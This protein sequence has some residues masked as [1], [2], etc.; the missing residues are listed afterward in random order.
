MVDDLSSSK[1][2]ANAIVAQ[3]NRQQ[4]LA[5]TRNAITGTGTSAPPIASSLEQKLLRM[6][7]LKLPASST[8]DNSMIIDPLASPYERLPLKLRQTYTDVYAVV[9]F[10]YV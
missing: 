10:K 3:Y 2:D 1:L 6:N 7:R 4:Q 8:I 5:M 9:R